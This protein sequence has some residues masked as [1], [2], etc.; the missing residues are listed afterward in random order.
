MSTG[1]EKPPTGLEP[2]WSSDRQ[3]WWNG[4]QWL[5]AS[6]AFLRKPWTTKQ[7]VV[8]FIAVGIGLL[9]VAPIIWALLLCATGSSACT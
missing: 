4:K 8:A 2:Q 9:F 7:K 1:Q 5:P 3:W 6:Q